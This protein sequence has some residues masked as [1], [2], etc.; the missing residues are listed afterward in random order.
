MD[1]DPE[2]LVNAPL[3]N[4]VTRSLNRMFPAFFATNT[5]HDHWKD[6]GWPENLT[7]AQLYRIYTRNGLAAAAVDRTI[8][9][10]WESN[11]IIWESEKP[12]E[13]VAEKD[14]RRAFQRLRLWQMAQEADRR[15]M[16]GRY[17]GLILRLRDDQPFSAPVERVPGGLDGIAEVIPAWE[18]QLRVAQWDFNPQSET[19]GRPVM[20]EFSEAAVGDQ[21]QPRQFPVHPDRVV[22][23]SDDGTVNCRSALEPGYN[24]II[25][26]E[27]VKGAGG[28][29]FWKSS[30]GAPV[31]QAPEGVTP[32]Q[33]AEGMG[34][35]LADLSDEINNQVDQ[36]QKG[37]DKGLLLGG[38]TATPMQIT[39]P[40]PEQFF[41]APVASFAASVQMPVKILIGNQTGERASTEDSREWAQT[42]NSRRT[43]RVLPIL[44]EMID[45]LVAWNVLPPADWHIEWADLTE[46]TAAE[47]IERAA[48]M[49][50][51]NMQT[52]PGDDPAFTPD[53]IREVA[54]YAPTIE[55]D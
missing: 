41:N 47:K 9:K 54:G 15:S 11:P 22:I 36:F 13:S 16:V 5:K 25:D 29:G 21:Q 10:T 2:G 30:R 17:A 37:F 12:A 34:V 6:F 55:G 49:A 8:A 4:T 35:N 52:Q 31:I 3:I 44:H 33:V 40:L 38:M 23:W 27:K 46:A 32:A 51:I 43:N 45:R 48:K 50:A 24:D 39:L 14:I 18:E 7:F 53:E 26:A 19:Y 20:F 1:P 42:C 28:E